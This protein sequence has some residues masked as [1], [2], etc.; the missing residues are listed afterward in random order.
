MGVDRFEDGQK[1]LV[2]TGRF[3]ALKRL[4]SSPSPL[5]RVLSTVVQIAA[6]AVFSLGQQ[7]L[8]CSTIAS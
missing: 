8:E 6:L 7:L 1:A 3:K 5:V 4:F 2:M